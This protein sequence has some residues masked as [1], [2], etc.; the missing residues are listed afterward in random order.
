MMTTESGSE[1]AR[2]SAHSVASR[3]RR[4]GAPVHPLMSANTR[5]FNHA[6]RDGKRSAAPVA[7]LAHASRGARCDVGKRGAATGAMISPSCAAIALFS[8]FHIAR[9]TPRAFSDT[10]NSGGRHCCLSKPA[11][12]T[13]RPAAGRVFLSTNALVPTSPG[14]VTQLPRGQSGEMLPPWVKDRSACYRQAAL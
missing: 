6:S 14:N 7:A 9:E 13:S 5:G 1:L 2:C 4:G 10:N 8:L 3:L 11:F 12:R